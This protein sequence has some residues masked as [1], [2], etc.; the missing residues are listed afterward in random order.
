MKPLDILYQ[1]EH[2][3]A[4]HKPAGMLVHRTRMSDGTEFALQALRGQL[5]QH[6]FPVHRLDRPTTGVLLFGLHAEAARELCKILEAGG[7]QKQYLAIVRGYTEAEALIDYPLKK[8]GEGALQ[9]ARTRYRTLS[10]IELPVPV[11]RY[12]T[13]RY[14]K[15]EVE[16]LTGR[17]HQIRRHF[18]HIRHPVLGDRK[19]GDWRHNKMLEEEFGIRQLMLHAWRLAFQHPYSQ[20]ALRIVAPLKGPMA[21]LSE[22]WDWQCTQ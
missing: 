20:E 7:M 21:A 3:V 14:A 22:G 15:V 12:Q 11:G 17:M 13:A 8:D 9:E 5:R 18:A 16:P 2:L 10:T 6:V 4:I 19:H 1:D